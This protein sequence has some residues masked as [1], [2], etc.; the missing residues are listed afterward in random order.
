MDDVYSG[1]LRAKV[2][3]LEIGQ[4]GYQTMQILT[5]IS[6]AEEKIYKYYFVKKVS[7][8]FILLCDLHSPKYTKVESG[9]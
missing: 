2:C 8:T 4:N 5:Q 6:N 1:D 7:K 9:G 3:C